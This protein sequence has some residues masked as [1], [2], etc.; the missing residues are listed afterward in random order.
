MVFVSLMGVV[1]YSPVFLAVSDKR[2]QL[3]CPRSSHHT[4]PDLVSVSSLLNS[5]FVGTYTVTYALCSLTAAEIVS[6]WNNC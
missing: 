5:L 2:K 3:A 1:C 4:D 6:S